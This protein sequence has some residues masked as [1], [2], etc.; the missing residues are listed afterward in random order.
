MYLLFFSNDLS[1][2]DLFLEKGDEI[3]LS[4]AKDE[5]GNQVYILPNGVSYD[6]QG[7]PLKTKIETGFTDTNQLN[8]SI[9]DQIDND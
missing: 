3:Q 9:L 5:S 8:V 4:V 7:K 6:K 1:T 2:M